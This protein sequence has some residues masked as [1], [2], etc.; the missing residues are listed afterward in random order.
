[1]H[2]EPVLQQSVSQALE[3]LF[4]IQ[5]PAASVSLQ[6]TRKDFEGSHTF[7]TFPYAKQTRKSPDERPAWWA[8]TSKAAPAS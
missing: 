7:V 2:I 5:I 8:N 6:P 4:G 1:M 3:E